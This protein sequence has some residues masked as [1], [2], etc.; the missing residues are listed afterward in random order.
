MERR[1]LAGELELARRIQLALLPSQLPSV[2]GYELLAG[3]IPSRGVSGD[4]YTVDVHPERGLITCLVCDVSGKGMAASLLGASLEALAVGPIEVGHP[5]DQIC[6]RVS[7]RLF[8]R[9]PPEKY[10]TGFVA[11]LDP[12]SHRLLWTNAGHNSAVLARRDGAVELLAASGPPIGLLPAATY[13]AQATEMGPGDFLL[14]YTDGITEA[15][16]PEGEEFGIER[17]SELVRLHR[18]APLDEARGAIETALDDFARGVP[19]AD[20]RTM[21]LLRR[22]GG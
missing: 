22:L 4:L 5:P 21:L 19:F 13:T 11:Q 20:D 2:P 18:A 8:A 10:A 6:V 9:T 15:V 14:V 1:R 3:N 12:A 16:D 7:R 17:L